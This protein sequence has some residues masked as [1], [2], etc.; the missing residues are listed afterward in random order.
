LWEGREL[1]HDTNTLQRWG[2][3]GSGRLRHS[4]EA[5]T[6]S[7]PRALIP[8]SITGP[9]T[10]ATSIDITRKLTTCHDYLNQHY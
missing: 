7:E 1:P 10:M 8:K 5:E 9:L 3:N 4:S 2:G 6:E